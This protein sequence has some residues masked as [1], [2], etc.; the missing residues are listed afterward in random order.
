MLLNA[1]IHLFFMLSP[2]LLDA[3]SEL[4]PDPLIQMALESTFENIE[5]IKITF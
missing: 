4:G 3:K 2:T 1:R 5:R